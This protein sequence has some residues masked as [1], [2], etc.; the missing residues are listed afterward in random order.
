MAKRGRKPKN[1]NILE[2]IDPKV[3]KEVLGLLVGA[4]AVIVIL[5]EFGVA[6][7]FGKT[8]FNG[9]HS[10]FGVVAY[11]F[12]FW[13]ALASVMFFEP[14][15]I[16]RSR[17]ILWG[18]LFLLIFFSALI[19]PFGSSSGMLGSSIYYSLQPAIGDAGTFI[20]MLVG[21]LGMLLLISNASLTEVLKKI[22]ST[23]KNAYPKVNVDV[24]PAPR[25]SVFKAVRRR[26]GMGEKQQ[27]AEVHKPIAPMDGNWVF[28][29][30][31]LLDEIKSTAQPGNVSKNVETLLKTLGDFG[32]EVTAGK[33]NVGPTVTQYEL[34]PSEGVKLNT[35]KAR[36]D[37]LALALAVHPVRVEAPIPGKSA[38]GVEVPNKEAARVSL[39]RGRRVAGRSSRL[40]SRPERIWRK[41]LRA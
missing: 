41:Q 15:I 6:G 24:N 16:K 28:P 37:D 23:T 21:T 3:I 25:I 17:V 20:F 2:S 34:K 14:D 9:F 10:F 26:I 38:V 27:V 22:G 8:I 36:A 33:I 39:R 31:D 1:P 32:V 35:I 18:S 30:T 12:A 40:H 11:I 7:S 5:A 4:L 13:L 19:A 29:D